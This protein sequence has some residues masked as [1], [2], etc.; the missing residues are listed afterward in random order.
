[1]FLS[2]SLSAFSN[3][4][5][6]SSRNRTRVGC[7][8]SFFWAKQSSNIFLV[9]RPTTEACS[10][11]KTMLFMM[12]AVRLLAY[13]VW[14]AMNRSLLSRSPEKTSSDTSNPFR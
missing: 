13:F 2:C 11:V 10:W 8:F 9:H 7:F 14:V 12:A 4:L 6:I 1:M 3:S 5:R